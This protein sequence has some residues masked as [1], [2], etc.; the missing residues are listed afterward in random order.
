M[1]SR[2]R[3][4]AAAVVAPRVGLAPRPGSSGA[5]NGGADR[6]RPTRIV[7]DVWLSSIAALM[8]Q[9]PAASRS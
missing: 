8:L 1:G 9:R 6:M 3:D 2:G 4:A 5:A 7:A